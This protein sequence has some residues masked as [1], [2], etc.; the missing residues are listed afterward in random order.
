MSVKVAPTPKKYQHSPRAALAHHQRC[1]KRA[2]SKA[3][4]LRELAARYPGDADYALDPAE[5]DALHEKV[6][7]NLRACIILN[8]EHALGFPVTTSMRQMLGM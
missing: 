6:M 1:A 5:M 7:Q 2:Q 4:W 3:D 8:D